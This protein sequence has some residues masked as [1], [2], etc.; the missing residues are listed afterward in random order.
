MIL[1]TAF[2]NTSSKKLIKA[3]K[4]YGGLIMENDNVFVKQIQM[5]LNKL[6]QRGTM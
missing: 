4:E 6:N 2:K 5:L 3:L 1:L